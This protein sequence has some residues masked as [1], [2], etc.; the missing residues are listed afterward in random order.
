LAGAILTIDPQYEA[1]MEFVVI[2][3]AGGIILVGMGKLNYALP[4]GLA[5]VGVWFLL[6]DTSWSAIAFLLFAIFSI[7]RRVH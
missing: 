5:A 3:I 1:L 7:F 2:L 4:A 6:G